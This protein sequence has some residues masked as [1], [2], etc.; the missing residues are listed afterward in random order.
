MN[1]RIK[2]KFTLNEPYESYLFHIAIEN[3]QTNEYFSEKIVNPLL[4]ECVPLYL[5]ARKIDKYFKGMYIL[6]N[7]NVDHD[8]EVIREVLRNQEKFRREYMPNPAR[9][10][11]TMNLFKNNNIDHAYGVA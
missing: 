3:F 5:G 10:E 9:V 2:G 1:R 8:I 6:L 7:G 4:H 11:S